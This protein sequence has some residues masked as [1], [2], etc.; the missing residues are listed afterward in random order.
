LYC[1]ARLGRLASRTI[2]YGTM[3]QP[4]V[5]AEQLKQLITQTLTHDKNIREPGEYADQEQE[6][7]GSCH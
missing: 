5:S 6:R 3:E 4:T 1:L 2:R 7:K